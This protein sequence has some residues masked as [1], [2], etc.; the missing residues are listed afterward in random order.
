VTKDWRRD[1]PILHLFKSFHT[2]AIKGKRRILS[3]KSYKG[4]CYYSVVTD[5]T[6]IEVAEA[7]EGLDPFY[8]AR[9]F[10]VADCFDLLRVNLDSFRTNDKPKVL[11]SFYP[12]LTF[13]NINL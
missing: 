3:G 8:G 5:K 12:E 13:L 11:C 4:L 9:G 2:V 6:A 10:P 7:K 1:K